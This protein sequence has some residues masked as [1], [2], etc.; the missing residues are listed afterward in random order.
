MNKIRILGIRGVPAA[1]GGFETF[2]HHFSLYLV[3]H[4]WDVE[5]FCQSTSGPRVLK[6]SWM[7]VSRT[8]VR[9]PG[10]TSFWSIIFDL[11]CVLRCIKDR[12][13]CLVLGYNTAVFTV[14]L[15]IFRVP[16]SI[17][18]DGI[19]WKRAKWGRL[20]KAW[21]W[22]N[23]WMGCLLGNQLIA[24]NPGIA[25]HLA[26]RGVRKK[27]I[28]IPY[29]AERVEQPDKNRL[30][31]FSLKAGEFSTLIARPEPENSVLEIVET[32]SSKPRNH[33]LVVLG[34]YS[35]ASGYKKRVLDA[36]S[37]EVVF[38]GAIYDRGVVGALRFYSRI[39]FHG[40]T[41]GGT[42]PSLVEAMGA[43]NAIV[44]HGNIYNRWVLG[45][46]GYYFLNSSDLEFNISR[47]LEDPAKVMDAKEN[48]LRR[49]DR[50]F[51]LL[52]IHAQ[53]EWAM[54]KLINPHAPIPDRLKNFNFDASE[55]LA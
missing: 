11:L 3:E 13:P 4:G 28:M 36:A 7:G 25:D 40:H 29:G 53:Y 5:V 54:L 14:L 6:D 17:N 46:G 48:A 8:H 22:F 55:R 16:F 15:R 9:V 38:V 30:D 32:F 37:N 20:A 49:F 43:G 42:N 19:E 52:K 34:N 39:Y 23:D 2:A 12:T 18:M 35:E 33:K 31:Q 24:D 10:D 26:T 1:H 21:F 45:E 47:L 51:S 44:A 41:V 50:E 27:V